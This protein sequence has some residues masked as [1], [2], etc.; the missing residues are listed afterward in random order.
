MQPKVSIL[1]PCYNAERWVGQAIESALVQTWPNKE[2]IV[3]DD[4]STDGSREVIES[5]RDKIRF[6]FGPNKG[7]NPC[8]NRLLEL[9][10]GEWVQFLDAD[11]YL[12]PEK[13]S[14]QM[15]CSSSS[16]V[17]YGPVLIRTHRGKNESEEIAEPSSNSDL[18]EQW[19]R[20]QVCQTGGLLWKKEAL[21]KIGGWNETFSC[22]QD[23]EVCLRAIQ[24][25]LIFNYCPKPGAV[26]RLWSEETVCRKYPEKV[27]SI[28]QK[29]IQLMLTWLHENKFH[30]HCHTEAAGQAMFEMSRTL[31]KKSIKKAFLFS[32]QWKKKGLWNPAGPA[33]TPAFYM[34]TKMFGFTISIILAKILHA[35]RKNS[36]K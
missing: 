19:I 23:N 31:A 6:E 20:W 21:K 17:V 9:A 15:K 25:G 12:L 16:D 35:F 29:L 13:I 30:Q 26:Y 14:E 33:V 24:N 22:C 1:I 7:G 2:V 28:K 27:I 10:S 18:F 5:F 11:D 4:G 3:V 8:R 34:A 36:I 32:E